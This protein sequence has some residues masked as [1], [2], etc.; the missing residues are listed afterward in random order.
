MRV[1]ISNYPVNLPDILTKI[2]QNQKPVNQQRG[3]RELKFSLSCV[4]SPTSELSKITKTI[5]PKT[6]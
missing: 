6:T 5:T 1:K 3:E 2:N 4:F